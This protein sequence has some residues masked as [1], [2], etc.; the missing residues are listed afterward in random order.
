L[1]FDRN[2][3]PPQEALT[4]GLAVDSPTVELQAAEQVRLLLEV[5]HDLQRLSLVQADAK[6]RRSLR[7]HIQHRLES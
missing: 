2:S 5:I 6:R 3:G 7:Q 1:F 4:A